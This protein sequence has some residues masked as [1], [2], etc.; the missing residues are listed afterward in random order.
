[1]LEFIRL[2]VRLRW[3]LRVASLLFGRW[4]PYDPGYSVDPYP[5]YARLRE[6]AP[7][8]K[9]PRKREGR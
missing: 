7:I 3:P 6:E 2:L 5:I 9:H 4:N 8:Y 1:M